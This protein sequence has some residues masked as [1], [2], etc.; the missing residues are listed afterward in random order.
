MK[1]SKSYE[2]LT[3]SYY[4]R[5]DYARK[6]K[7]NN[8][9]DY[10]NEYEFDLYMKSNEITLLVYELRRYES[11]PVWE[12]DAMLDIH[13]DHLD[14]INKKIRKFTLLVDKM[15]TYNLIKNS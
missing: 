13:K 1:I 15:D 12:P 5:Y 2:W 6:Y 14:I 9:Q 7:S 11:I 8:P 3:S 10:A 4:L